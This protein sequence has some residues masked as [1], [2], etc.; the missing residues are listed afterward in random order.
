MSQTASSPTP[1]PKAS[2]CTRAT[3]G[4]GKPS[5]S[6]SMPASLR[7]SRSRAAPSASN[8]ARIQAKSPP[9]QNVA[10]SLARTTT[11]TA[12][13]APNRS[14]APAKASIMAA[15]IALRFSGLA[16]V[17]VATPRLSTS[18][19]TVIP[20]SPERGSPRAPARPGPTP[21]RTPAPP[22]FPPAP[23]SPRSRPPR[24]ERAA[25]KPS[26][27]GVEHPQ[28]PRQSRLDVLERPP[29]RVVEMPSEAVRG[30]LLQHRREHRVHPLGRTLP[31]RLPQR[32]L[33]APE[34]PQRRRDLRDR[35][36]ETSPS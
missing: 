24:R 6:A 11:R 22:A 13:S 31:E 34:V 19:R 26:R 12:G 16:S 36:G 15:S 29:A 8:C 14:A 2:P 30:H 20:A 9:A 1:P 21:S 33:A 5:Q 10:P 7:A 23:R 32:H 3:T 18:T 28:P 4:F 25:A 35:R 27:R 17:T